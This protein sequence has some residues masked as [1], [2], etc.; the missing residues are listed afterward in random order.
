MIFSKKKK[1]SR[2]W[3]LYLWQGDKTCKL[4]QQRPQFCLSTCPLSKLENW[5]LWEQTMV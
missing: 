5:E 2:W 3:V 4:V 1:K